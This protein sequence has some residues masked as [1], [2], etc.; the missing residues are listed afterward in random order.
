[1]RKVKLLAGRKYLEI[2]YPLNDLYTKYRNISEKINISTNFK[3]LK[4]SLTVCKGFEETLYKHLT[5]VT[6]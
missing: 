6:T 3:N 2:I 5:K 4:S 1:M